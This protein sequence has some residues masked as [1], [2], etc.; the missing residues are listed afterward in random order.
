MVLVNPLSHNSY[1]CRSLLYLNQ[2]T[3]TVE[4]VVVWCAETIVA[5]L[6]DTPIGQ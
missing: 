1:A 4:N 2:C 5:D 6:R 3:L